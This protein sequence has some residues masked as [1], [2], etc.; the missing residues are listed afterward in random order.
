MTPRKGACPNPL[1]KKAEEKHRPENCRC[2]Y[3][4]A[5][6]VSATANAEEKGLLHIEPYGAPDADGS[7]GNYSGIVDG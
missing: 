6:V 2:C 4:F 3:Q 1:K 5:H 7:L